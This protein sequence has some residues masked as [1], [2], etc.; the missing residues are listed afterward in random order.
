[1]AMKLQ[2]IDLVQLPLGM[3]LEFFFTKNGEVVGAEKHLPKNGLIVDDGESK[4]IIDGVQAEINPK[5]GT[6]RALIANGIRSCF[7]DL[8]KHIKKEGV[9]CT[10]DGAVQVSDAEFESLSDDS[11]KFGC[12]PSFD[13]YG[14]GAVNKIKVD[15]LTHRG[16]TAGGHIHLG[17][18]DQIT[19]SDKGFDPKCVACFLDCKKTL[20]DGIDLTQYLGK[21]TF[22]P[23]DKDKEPEKFNLKH[24]T[25]ENIPDIMKMLK[26]EYSEKIN[27]LQIGHIS[28]AL[29]HPELVI[30]MMDLIIG[31]ASVLLD[32]DPN[33]KIRRQVYGRAGDYR[34]PPH[35]LEYRTL[36]NFW[37]K[38]YPLT[39]LMLGL[40]RFA[41]L[42]VAEDVKNGAFKDGVTPYITEMWDGIDPKDVQ[43]AINENDFVM[44]RDIWLKIEPKL[45]M[46]AGNRYEDNYPITK[47]THLA[48]KQ[49][50]VDGYEKHF[51]N[52]AIKNWLDIEDNTHHCGWEHYAMYDIRVDANIN[53]LFEKAVK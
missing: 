4:F 3:D 13:A 24:I 45:L 27:K 9:T 30:P 52:D 18:Y 20:D 17:Y 25:P 38:S 42:I 6:C 39:S 53:E 43:K 2:A 11:K 12:M 16:R 46:C 33:A 34:T 23:S 29:Q 7:V 10:F 1:M 14:K 40:A 5:Q 51:G 26:C 36:S 8:Q 47:N 35:G 28:R 21:A 48:F 37:I 32:R 41:L 49:F 31:I 22:I 19:V 15:P 44:A 50:V